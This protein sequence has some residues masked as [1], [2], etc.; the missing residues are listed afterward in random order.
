MVKDGN[1]FV[2]TMASLTVVFKTLQLSR[3]RK[4]ASDK[5]TSKVYSENFV[6]NIFIPASINTFMSLWA[7]Q[8]EREKI[9]PGAPVSRSRAWLACDCFST[10]RDS[11]DKVDFKNECA[12]MWDIWP[13]I[14]PFSSLVK[15]RE[16][17]ITVTSSTQCHVNKNTLQAAIMECVPWKRKEKHKCLSHGPQLGQSCSGLNYSRL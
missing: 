11:H 14:S 1:I 9:F 12:T 10:H 7:N 4:F 17:W 5:K 15:T 13:P 2:N 8:I 6:G 16:L 3:K